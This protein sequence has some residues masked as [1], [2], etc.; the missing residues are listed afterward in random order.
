MHSTPLHRYLVAALFFSAVASFLLWHARPET[1]SAYRA[2]VLAPHP[3]QSP[4]QTSVKVPARLQPVVQKIK[5]PI[6][7]KAVL[8]A[9]VTGARLNR[10]TNTYLV[11]ISGNLLC[12]RQPCS[13]EIQLD[14]ETPK[15]VDLHRS[16]KTSANGRFDLNVS[17][18]EFSKEQL[19]WRLAADVPGVGH[20]E[21]RG[22]RILLEDPFLSIETDLEIQ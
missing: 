12:G 4:I 13:G 20:T 10:F 7:K 3:M 19:D 22:H 8:P 9:E 16:V 2:T 18:I 14:L 11:S 1:T 15:H 17:V 6:S 5:P 21:A